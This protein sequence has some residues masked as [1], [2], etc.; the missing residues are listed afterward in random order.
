MSNLID[1]VRALPRH[2]V[3]GYEWECD[4]CSYDWQKSTYR[5]SRGT[6]TNHGEDL[7]NVNDVL[8]ILENAA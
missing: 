7:I 3:G 1:R 2:P 4:E 5:D 8:D 6:P